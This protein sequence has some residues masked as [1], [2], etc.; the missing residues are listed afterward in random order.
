MAWAL[1][2]RYVENCSCDAIC[3]CTWSN[4]SLPATR[5]D[6]RA[7]LAFQVDRGVVEDVDVAGRTVVLVLDTPKMMTDGNWRVGLIIDGD[8]TPQQVDSLS[9]VFTGEIGGPFAALSPLIAEVVGVEQAAIR[10]EQDAEGWQLR[11]GDDGEFRG[12]TARGPEAP[13]AV[14]LTGIVIHPAG[15]TLT[16]TPGDGVRSS[17]FGIEWS[18]DGRS[19]FAAPFSWAA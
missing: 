18:G 3:P 11:V 8:A 16:V 17:L 7:V 4:L 2:G 13:D 15:P 1:E 19:G 10:L 9:M 6:C 5:D 12:T 14:T